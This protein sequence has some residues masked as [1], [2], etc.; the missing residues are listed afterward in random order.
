[1][2]ERLTFR[3]VLRCA[4]CRYRAR[5][6]RVPF[7]SELTFVF[8][9]HT[10]CIRCGSAR[11]RRLSDRDRIDSMSSHPLSLLLALT[12][13]PIHHCSPCRLQYRDWRG[14]ARENQQNG[15]HAAVSASAE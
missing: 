8:S 13:A 7:E 3:K 4:A 9:R 2:L 12:F 15:T 11:V 6:L 1:L 10:R 14:V 5:Q